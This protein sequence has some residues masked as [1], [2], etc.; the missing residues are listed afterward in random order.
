MVSP[1]FFFLI[2]KK[3]KKEMTFKEKLEKDYPGYVSALF[4]GGGCKGCPY[5]YGYEAEE[6][7]PC[8]KR[9]NAPS[10]SITCDA[11]W[12]RTIPTNRPAT[13][14]KVTEPLRD[15]LTNHIIHYAVQDV[16]SARKLCEKL[17][18]AVAIK[19]PEG[20]PII[21][22]VKFS[23]PATVIFWADDTKTVVKCQEGDTYNPETGF[24][25]AYL[26]KLLGN[27]NTFNKEIAKWVGDIKFTDEKQQEKEMHIK[28][29]Y[30]ALDSFLHKDFKHITKAQMGCMIE[31]ALNH[32]MSALD[33]PEAEQK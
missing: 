15:R 4:Y 31:E 30:N 5:Q 21:K 24:A 6:D 12:N 19:T 1:L 10:G 11:C 16:I 33:F 9:I 7:R 3:E 26:K 17:S 27:D 14:Q 2:K 29:A 25:L 22:R 28:K 8:A 20:R 18:S 32:L 23:P 13:K